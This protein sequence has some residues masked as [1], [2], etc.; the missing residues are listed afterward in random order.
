[1]IDAAL[2]T[3]AFG[4]SVWYLWRYYTRG[5]RRRAA[6]EQSRSSCPPHCPGCNSR[7]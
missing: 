5:R 7:E 2:V 6:A 4:V 1:M 3:C